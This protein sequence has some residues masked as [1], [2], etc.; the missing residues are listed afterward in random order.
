MFHSINAGLGV[1]QDAGVQVTRQLE[2]CCMGFFGDSAGDIKRDAEVDLGIIHA[3]LDEISHHSFGVD[4]IRRHL[5]VRGRR[6]AVK[7]AARAKDPR[8]GHFAL[9]DCIP[10]GQNPVERIT[11][12]ANGR[13]PMDEKGLT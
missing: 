1:W 7:T 5:M 9:S 10:L 3:L 6:S 12:I 8:S 4:R 13:N 11:E 2:T